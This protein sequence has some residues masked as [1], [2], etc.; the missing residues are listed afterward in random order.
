M[1]KVATICVSLA[2]KE[3]EALDA[4]ARQAGSRSAAVRELIQTRRREELRRARVEQYRAYYATPGAHEQDRKLTKEMQ[5]LASWPEDG[6]MRGGKHA[7]KR[8]PPR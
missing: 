3:V 2:P 1:R 4:M 7:G 6:P 8:R 5:G